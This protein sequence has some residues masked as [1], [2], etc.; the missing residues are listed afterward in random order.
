ML[1]FHRCWQLFLKNFAD[2]A[3]SGISLLVNTINLLSGVT[4]NTCYGTEW[5]YPVLGPYCGDLQELYKVSRKYCA[6]FEELYAACNGCLIPGFL[7]NALS[8]PPEH[9]KLMDAEQADQWIN[10]TIQ[11]IRSGSRSQA[12]KLKRQLKQYS[13]FPVPV[14]AVCFQQLNKP[15][16]WIH[17]CQT[18]LQCVSH[19][20]I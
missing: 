6:N 12:A 13:L 18:L 3:A 17:E 5:I 11:A 14:C 20:W 7:L 9:L 8:I 1:L 16:E 2:Y 10:E 19:L 15:L 4:I